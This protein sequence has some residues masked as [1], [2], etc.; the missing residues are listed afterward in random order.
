MNIALR[1][2]AL[3]VVS[4]HR[5]DKMVSLVR[6]TAAKDC[7]PDEFD[8]FVSVARELNLNPLRK[9]IYAFVFD[10][11]DPAKRNMSLVIG[12][13]GG[14][15]IAARTGNYRPDNEEP[16]WVFDPELKNPLTN[17]HGIEK[18]TVGVWHRP[19]KDD[20]FERIVHTVY[21]DEFAP[22]VTR[23]DESAYEWVGT[24][25]FYPE[26]HQRAGREIQKKQLREGATAS[27]A[28]RLDPNKKQWIK[29]G[30]NQ[31]AKCAEMGALRK[32][33]PEDLSRVV[34]EEETHRAEAIQDVE[35]SELSPSEMVAKAESDARLAK[36]GGPSV[37]AVF[38]AAGTLESVPAGKFADRVIEH[39]AKMEPAGVADWMGRNRAALNEFWA[40]N[41]TDCLELKRTLEARSATVAA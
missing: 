22:I 7:D 23:A 12:I 16:K 5:D 25:N 40:H 10:K 24:G 13:D 31:I 21:W 29:S 3:P 38:D 35:W 26:G 32:G 19:T 11:A 8:L 18:C 2:A 1:T 27:I 14:R 41:K 17:P 36:I 6:R 15:A 30:R 37:L 4:W 28:E 34:V 9:Q 20:P 39:T 33:W